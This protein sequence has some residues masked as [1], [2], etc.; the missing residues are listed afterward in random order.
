MGVNGE[1]SAYFFSEIS[2]AVV[3][4]GKFEVHAS[5][6]SVA[7]FVLDANVRHGNLSAHDLKPMLFGDG[8]LAFG[9]SA[10]LTEFREV[11]VDPL[12]QFVVENDAK[13]SASLA[14]D[15]R[16]RFLIEPVEVG[17]VMG[18]ARFGKA[19]VKGLPFAGGLRL[20]EK[21]MAVLGESEQLAGA[22]FLV[23]NGFHFNEALTNEIFH[24]GSHAIVITAIGKF[25]EIL[26]GHSAEFPEFDHRCDFGV[27]EAIGSAAKFVDGAS[28]SEC[29]LAAD[30][31]ARGL[32]DCDASFEACSRASSALGGSA[33][34]GSRPSEDARGSRW[35]SG[36]WP[37]DISI[38]LLFKPRRGHVG[39]ARHEAACRDGRVFVP[40]P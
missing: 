35:S 30:V 32:V 34:F 25:R 16:G 29:A 14:F 2:A 5:P 36:W 1:S 21:A 3:T 17:V 15:L 27:P 19:V 13:V 38:G 8:A 12:L 7:R 26:P 20:R 4:G 28:F 39:L 6:F 22:R 31:L 11:V 24:V 9:G 40:C 18:F 33:A 10:I 37:R 23:R